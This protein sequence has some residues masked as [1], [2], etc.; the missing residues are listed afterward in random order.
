MN[1]EMQNVN[2]ENAADSAFMALGHASINARRILAALVV[3]LL[4][5]ASI[6]GKQR[7]EARAAAGVTTAT[8]A[9]AAE[10]KAADDG[11]PIG[12][13]SA[14]ALNALLDRAADLLGFDGRAVAGVVVA[15]AVKAWGIAT[16]R[17]VGSLAAALDAVEKAAAAVA[18]LSL[19][20]ALRGLL[21][22]G[23]EAVA[24]SSLT[25]AAAGVA[26]DA[27]VPLVGVQGI[28]IDRDANR[29]G[30]HHHMGE[31][32]PYLIEA[33]GSRGSSLDLTA[34]SMGPAARG[35]VPESR[36][37]GTKAGG[38]GKQSG[39]ADVRAAGNA[40][41]RC[42]MDAEAMNA[43]QLVMPL[44][45]VKR[46]LDCFDEMNGVRTPAAVLRQSGAQGAATHSLKMTHARFNR[47]ATVAILAARSGLDMDG[48]RAVEA[49]V[50]HGCEVR[51]NR[52]GRTTWV[53]AS[54]VV[55]AIDAADGH[56][57]HLSL[58]VVR[59]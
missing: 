20:P 23:V 26:A 14:V 33:D 49:M 29:A 5:A 43:Q 52:N 55:V 54:V 13:P 15:K 51:S 31:R 18:D 57:A 37:C 25:L 58:A 7:T 2:T 10:V 21:T 16:P 45:E 9:K 40:C 19:H 46:G 30:A 39:E 34:E 24:A 47:K 50:G 38:C 41:P 48:A 36:Y 28:T 8:T 6:T 53:P 12:A 27:R 4:K 42:G 56:G 22:V 44:P 32:R 59:D 1:P 35:A 11:R 17:I 3:V